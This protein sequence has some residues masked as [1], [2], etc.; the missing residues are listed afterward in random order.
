[1]AVSTY[2]PAI[3]QM[4]ADWRQHSWSDAI[5]HVSSSNEDQEIRI[6]V[7]RDYDDPD[8]Q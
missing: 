6:K 1:M 3:V 7:N 8:S 2:E 5:K 4:S